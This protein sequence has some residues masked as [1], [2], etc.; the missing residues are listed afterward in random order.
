[1]LMA[2]TAYN[3]Q[4]L[5]FCSSHPK[6]NVQILTLKQANTLYFVLRYVV[7]HPGRFYIP[8]GLLSHHFMALAFSYRYKWLKN[9]GQEVGPEMSQRFHL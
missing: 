3:L 4:K 7:Q 8:N 5:L 9:R 6:S 2:A 1:M